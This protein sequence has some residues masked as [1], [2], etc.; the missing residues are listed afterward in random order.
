AAGR[1][2]SVTGPD[3][4]SSATVIVAGGPRQES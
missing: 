1:P 4:S 2:P 3:R